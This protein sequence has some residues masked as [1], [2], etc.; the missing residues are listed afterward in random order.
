MRAFFILFL[1]M[2]ACRTE[3]RLGDA[4]ERACPQNSWGQCDELEL[5]RCY[6]IVTLAEEAE[7]HA[8]ESC[9]FPTPGSLVFNEILLDGEPTEASEFIE[10]VSLSPVPLRIDGLSIFISKS[11]GY[12]RHI[13]LESGCV[14]PNGVLLLRAEREQPM[15]EPSWRYE[16]RYSK[17]RFGFSNKNPFLAQ[18]RDGNDA[19]LDEVAL[20]PTAVTPGVSLV[21][22]PELAGDDFV[23]HRLAGQGALSSPGRCVDFQAIH[24]GCNQRASLC[25]EAPSGRISI[26]E[27]MNYPEVGEQEFI[28]L[29]NVSEANVNLAGLKLSRAMMDTR[30]ML[31]EI[32]SGCLRP[33]ER[34]AFYSGESEP[35][36]RDSLLNGISADVYSFRLPNQSDSVISLTDQ[37]GQELDV[38][39]SL[40]NQ[41]VH[42]VSLNRYPDP[43]F[44]SITVHDRYF[45]GSSSPGLAPISAD[46]DVSSSK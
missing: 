37:L 14:M 8:M 39:T 22:S 23:D 29:V 32:W 26:A 42:G 45:Y 41:V 24:S 12:E 33:N 40:A 11:S 27:V 44:G 20:D 15:T 25:D 28:E 18:L 36:A 46:L 4:C 6:D 10:I 16:P 1:L 35:L 17:R 9:D 13:E 30:R 21:R 3:C 38:F 7:L 34:V 43:S 19:L 31:V 5:C 2:C